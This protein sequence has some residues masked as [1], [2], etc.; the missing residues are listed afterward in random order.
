MFVLWSLSL[1]RVGGSPALVCACCE[2]LCGCWKLSLDPLQ[3]KQVFLMTKPSLKFLVLFFFEVHR[4]PKENM[5]SNGGW[6]HFTSSNAKYFKTRQHRILP[7]KR[8]QH[9]SLVIG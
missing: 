6:C 7:K 5:V 8:S 4:G 9:D 2:P 1:T 3:E